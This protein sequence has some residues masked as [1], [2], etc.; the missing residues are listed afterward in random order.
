[1]VPL[2]RARWPA[3]AAT[4]SRSAAHLWDSRSLLD[5]VALEHLRGA[6]DGRALRV[7]VLRR[8]PLDE[9]INAL[10]FWFSELALAAPDLARMR[11]IAGPMLA[12]RADATPSVRWQGVEL[13]RH[14]DRLH[15][16]V[17]DEPGS[18]APVVE[19]ERWH[20][21]RRPWVSLG[22]AGTLELA[23][24]LHGDVR[25]AALPAILSVRYRLGG[26]RLQGL[27][28]RL[29][30]KDLLQRHRLAPWERS[31]VPLVMHERTVVAVGD[32]WLAP[33]FAARSGTTS[34]RARFRWRHGGSD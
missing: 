2:L 12:A 10:R 24:D 27:Q 19:L 8:L 21:R 31:H 22:A 5:R 3:A 23:P 15:A 13:R 30:L 25:L 18:S 7:S 16:C 1:V 28:G 17:W 26:E 6:R 33:E 14:A 20:W 4:A 34:G 9:R 29:T 11:E 32:L